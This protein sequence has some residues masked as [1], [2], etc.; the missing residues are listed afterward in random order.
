MEAVQRQQVIVRD[1]EVVVTGLPYKKGET[2]QIIVLGQPDASPSRLTVG[3]LRQSGLIG[4]WRD[5]TD[6]SDSSA[7]ARQLRHGDA[8]QLPSLEDVERLVKFS[9]LFGNRIQK[10]VESKVTQCLMKDGPR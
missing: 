4:M 2:V 6:I 3:R 10:D 1:G 8:S 5:R 7:Y 9:Q